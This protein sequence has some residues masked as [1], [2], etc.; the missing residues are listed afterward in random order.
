M[1][2]PDLNVYRNVSVINGSINGDD[3]NGHGTIVAGIAAA[4]D[5]DIGIAGT[6]PGARI[7]SI[8][9]CDP[10]GECKITNQMKGVEYAIQHADEIDILNISIE[11]PNSPAL[12][13]LIDQAVK[14]GIT[15]VVSA[16]NHGKDA[17]S[18]S[19]ANNPNVI[20]VSAIADSDG[21]CG[22]A[23]P[24]LTIPNIKS[25]LPDDTFASFSNFGPAV[26]I[27]APG[28]NILSTYKD[29]GYA[30]DNGTSMAAPF[31]SGY[32]A[33]YKAQNPYSMP[34]E[35]MS[36]VLGAG[37]L[38][39]TVCDGGSHGYFEGDIDTSHEPLL[40]YQQISR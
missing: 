7:W 9:A 18:T 21:I 2:H 31:V 26:K 25:N 10:L 28:V 23:G 15:V 14:A 35:V 19:P 34:P 36:S 3:G 11:N 20:T 13:N 16:G 27:A 22:G 32:A 5:N 40:Y 29:A 37:S 30:M 6:A 4:K 24:D 1:L 8:Q 38:P 12:N 39:N 33:L 17:S